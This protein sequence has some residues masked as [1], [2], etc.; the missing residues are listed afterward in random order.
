MDSPEYSER[1]DEI[2]VASTKEFAIEVALAKMQEEWAEIN[3]VLA[4][5]R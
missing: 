2:S 5:Y 4:Q 3:F 1:L